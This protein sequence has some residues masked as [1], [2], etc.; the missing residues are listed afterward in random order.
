[1]SFRKCV[2]TTALSLTLLMPTAAATNTSSSNQIGQISS[3]YSMKSTTGATSTELYSK[4]DAEL[5]PEVKAQMKELKAKLKNGEITKEQF[6]EEIKK[7]LPEGY[8]HKHKGKGHH[9]KLSDEDKAKL[10]ELKV[11]LENGEITK[12]EFMKQKKELFHKIP[13]VE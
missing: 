12:E 11:K 9:R 2:L 1:M 10:K 4:P 7:V 5:A 6:H 13:K 3:S 8:Q